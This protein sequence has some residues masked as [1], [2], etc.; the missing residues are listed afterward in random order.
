MKLR[1]KYPSKRIIIFMLIS[2]VIFSILTGSKLLISYYSTENSARI[3]LAKQYI[4]IANNIADELDKKA[5]EKFL[6]NPRV[7]DENRV[8]IK[9][10]LELYQL[11]INSLFTYILMLDESNISKVMV[12]AM[13]NGLAEIPIGAICT[14]PEA[15]IIQA[16]NGQKYFTKIISGEHNT[17]Y[18]SVGVPFYDDYGKILG[19]VG[20]D[21]DAKDLKQV[22]HQ[23]VM[24]NRIAFFIDILFA[25]VLILVV[26]LLHKWYKHKLT[27]DQKEIEKMYISELGKIVGTLKSSRHDLMNHIQVLNGLIYLKQYEKAGEYLKQLTVDSKALDVSLRIQN[28]ALM[29]ILQSKWELGQSKDIH[30]QFEV[31]QSD[32]SRIEAMDV[33]KILS[34]LLDNAIE[35]VDVYSGLEP[36]IIKVI[37]KTIGG[38]YIFSVENPTQLSSKEY[39]SLFQN[40][41][42]SKVNTDGLRGNGLDIISRVTIKYSGD[43]FTHYEHEKLTIQITI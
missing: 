18:F 14:V 29:V 12:T 4:E 26:F 21:I 16:K 11:K 22:S 39:K 32:F 10:F 20:I 30:I 35:A 36:K 1:K 43:I 2:I 5:Y 37:C 13:P 6:E 38:K 9:Q 34:N 28:P 23:V 31:D 27:Q 3:T 41:Y 25:I 40:G 42:T 19:V 24:N 15:Q 17:S 33:V 8:Q 7:N